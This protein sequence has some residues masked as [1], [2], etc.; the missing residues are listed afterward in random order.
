MSISVDGRNKIL[1]IKYYIENNVI[2]NFFSTLKM[3]HNNS[4]I[5]IVF[6]L[7]W[8]LEKEN[9]EENNN[10]DNYKIKLN[11]DL[12]PVSYRNQAQKNIK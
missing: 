8:E 10:E 11:F 4:K 7:K 9:E 3:I 1:I 2:K 12:L 5:E 6:T